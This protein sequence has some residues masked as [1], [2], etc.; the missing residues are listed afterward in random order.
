MAPFRVFLAAFTA[1]AFGVPAAFGINDLAGNPIPNTSTAG[2]SA[3]L[4]SK[5]LGLKRAVPFSA[6]QGALGSPTSPEEDLSAALSALATAPDLTAAETARQRVLDILRGTTGGTE[7]YQGIPLLN[8]TKATKNVPAGGTVTVKIV[9]FGEHQ[10]S[11]TDRLTFADPNQPFDVIYEITELGGAEGGDLTPTPLLHDGGQPVAGLHSVVE[12]LGLNETPTGTLQSSRFT[13]TLFP[14]DPARAEHTR[15]ATQTVRVKMPPPKNVAVILEPN[16][17][18]GHEAL[19]VLATGPGGSTVTEGEL[20]PNAP[21]VVLLNS[22]SNPFATV[23]DANTA[24][25]QGASQVQRMRVKSHL[26]AGVAPIAGADVTAAFLNNEL[27]L[28]DTNRRLGP[29]Q[30]IT[31][32]VKNLDLL[33]HTALVTELKNSD[34]VFG[35]T[36]WGAFRWGQSA[37]VAVAPGGGEQLVTVT[38]GSSAFTLVVGDPNTGGQAN[39]TIT[40]D[41]SPDQQS[42]KVPGPAFASPLH[43][44]FDGQG[45]VWMTLAGSDKIGRLTPTATLD[46][47]TSPYVEYHLPPPPAPFIVWEPTDIDVDAN[48]IVWATLAAGNAVLRLDPNTAQSCDPRAPLICSPSTSQGIEIIPLA[49]CQP[50]ECRVAPPPAPAE[51]PTRLPTQMALKTAADGS[52]EVWFTEMLADKIGVVR[53]SPGGAQQNHFTCACQVAAIGAPEV[54]AGNPSGLAVHPDGT[55]WFAGANR[56][57]IA[58]LTPPADLF[59]SSV[60]GVA[61]YAIVSRTTV[62]DPELGGGEFVTSAPHSVAIDRGGRVWFTEL[63]THKAG[64][65]EPSRRQAG[66]TQGMHEI[67]LGKNAFGAFLQPADLTTDPA[68]AV[69]V[70]DEYGDQ[71]TAISGCTIRD[72]FVPTRRLSFTDQPLVDGGG[73]LWFLEAGAN[74]ITRISGD[75]APAGSPFAGID[76][77]TGQAVPPLV[78]GNPAPTP[79]VTPPAP[80]ELAIACAKRQWAYGTA[81]KPKVLLLGSTG[82]QV[83]KCLGKPSKKTATLWTYGTRLK[84]TFARGRVT[85]FA[86][87]NKVFRSKVGNIGVGSTTASLKK[88]SKAKVTFER[89]SSRYVTVLPLSKTVGAK[90]VYNVVR[91]K[92]TRITVTQVKR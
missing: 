46:D 13:Q 21:E 63:A 58:Q 38:P 4:V 76:C 41:R 66:T 40:L 36:N 87:L 3:Q 42:F 84:V 25:A 39:A 81:A 86:V 47:A 8:V 20:A 19:S 30:A 48:G 57:T 18:P 11:D 80:D 53:W 51:A 73:N 23:G 72:R 92:V 37:S 22:V 75:G 45:R 33:S 88:L 60:A 32:G 15:I 44:A 54:N 82:A 85:S 83:T 91:G 6:P 50:G 34:P 74:L 59:G 27:Y 65:L 24:G 55:I 1:L 49:A 35:P 10:I 62:A 14:G 64:Y 71:I 78:I 61:H 5:Q 89:G 17:R 2:L 26:P 70:A 68:G 67:E 77:A 31:V 90:V 69:Y 12:G 52:T 9:R 7:A 16:L 29:G 56:N 79:S 43:Q 28:S